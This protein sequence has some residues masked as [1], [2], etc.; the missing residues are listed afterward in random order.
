[1]W[2][3]WLRFGATEYFLS[4]GLRFGDGAQVHFAQEALRA[5]GGD[6]GYG[7]SDILRG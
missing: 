5:L 1:M 2:F 6:H 4:A 3:R 7:V